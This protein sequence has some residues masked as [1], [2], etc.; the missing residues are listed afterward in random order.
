M[1]D[2]ESYI[3][4]GKKST[5]NKYQQFYNKCGMEEYLLMNTKSNRRKYLK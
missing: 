4:N 1:M 3:V 5:A 2:T